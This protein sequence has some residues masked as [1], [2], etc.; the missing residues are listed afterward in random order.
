MLSILLYIILIVGFIIWARLMLVWTRHIYNVTEQ[1]R[2]TATAE[3]EAAP[4]V[5]GVSNYERAEIIKRQ[6]RDMKITPQEKWIGRGLFFVPVIL[7]A[8]FIINLPL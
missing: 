7:L 3:G 1:R 4:D 2:V 5:K 6:H 8:V